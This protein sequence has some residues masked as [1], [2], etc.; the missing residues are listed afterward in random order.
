MLDRRSLAWF[1]FLAFALA[2][3]LFLAPLAVRGNES[4]YPFVMKGLFAL[5]MWGPGIAALVTT[6]WIE[7]R[8]FHSLRLHS[9]GPRGYYFWAWFLPPLIGVLTFGFTILLGT[10]QMDL[11]FSFMKAAIEK[12]PPTEKALPS[13]AVMVYSQVAFALTLAP[14]VNMLFA[15]GEELGWRGF[16]LPRLLPLGQWK[17][18]LLT[19]FIW[20]I[21]HA[22]TTI[23]HGYNFPLHPYVGVLIMTGG[24]I[25]L[26]II[27]A[28]LYLKTLSPWAP[29]LAHGAFNASAGVGLFFLKQ[30]GLDTALAAS[31]LGLAGWP[32]MALVIGGLLLLRQLPV[33]PAEAGRD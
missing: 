9:L 11:S 31:P 13:L 28:W 5:A 27:M 23:F 7:K 8:P 19:G 21:W 30:D 22:P 18:I 20:G 2:W 25:L 3:A 10:G 29:A 15:L 12:A 14:F 24:C 16:L 4:L 6:R 17:A 1:L 32:A 33:K 26:G